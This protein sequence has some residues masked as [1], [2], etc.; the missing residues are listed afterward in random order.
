MR[1]VHSLELLEESIESA[2]RESKS[3]FGNDTVFLEKYLDKP[4]HIEFQILADNHGNI[5][6]NTVMN[7]PDKQLLFL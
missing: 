7:I 2:K 6:L 3:S 4:R 5:I 1:I